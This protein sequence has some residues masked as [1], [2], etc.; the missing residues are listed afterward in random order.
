MKLHHFFA[1]GLEITSL[2]DLPV[3][4]PNIGI[5]NHKIKLIYD[6]FGKRIKKN[7]LK[8]V[9]PITNVHNIPVQLSSNLPIHLEEYSS[10]REWQLN[11][12]EEIYFTWK[13]S[14]DEL[15]IEYFQNVNLKKLSFWLLHTVLP[16]YLILQ[17]KSYIFHASSI[18]YNNRA[19]LFL[20]PSFGGKSTLVDFFVEKGHKMISDDKL[21]T[22]LDKGEFYASPSYPYRRPYR[23]YED[24]G[25]H[26]DLF[27][28]KPLPIQTFYLLNSVDMEKSI[29]IE[30][31]GGLKKFEILKTSYLYD[32][33][34]ITKRAVTYLMQISKDIRM[35]QVN[36]PRD[37]L[38]LQDVYD[39]IL[40]HEENLGYSK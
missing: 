19:I 35:Y 4:L 10:F 34:S 25:I 22:Y 16:V 23:K 39:C 29:S 40:K 9:T 38:Q 11:I 37:L 3:D 15:H 26:S 8:Y 2:I 6:N 21:S 12:E 1:Y 32:P 13:G 33:I 27:T 7:T 30:S 5:A 28:K 20:A 24:L 36:V 17:Q 18:E 14:I 31:M